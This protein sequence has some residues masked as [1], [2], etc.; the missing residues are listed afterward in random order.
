MIIAAFSDQS[1]N[2][3]QKFLSLPFDYFT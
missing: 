2:R 1:T 3:S